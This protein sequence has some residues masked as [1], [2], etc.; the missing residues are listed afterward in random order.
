MGMMP[1]KIMKLLN[2]GMSSFMRFK[3]VKHPPYI[4]HS[5]ALSA[6]PPALTICQ[7][8]IGNI[9]KVAKNRAEGKSSNTVF[10]EIFDSRLSEHEKREE[11]LLQEAQNISIAGTEST[12]WTLSVTIFYLLSNPACLKKL[13]AELQR[14]FPDESTLT[15]I[16]ALEQLPYLSAVIQEGLR[17]ALGTTNRK[18]RLNPDGPMR[19]FDARSGKEWMVPPKV[20]RKTPLPFSFVYLLPAS[21]PY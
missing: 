14:H 6:P 1:I 12:S 4:T 13:R 20:R 19:Y 18:A 5:T 8:L 17:L 9:R 2:P 15:S 10:D 3:Q 16:T 21:I 7:E 11:R